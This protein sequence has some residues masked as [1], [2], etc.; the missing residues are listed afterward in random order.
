MIDSVKVYNFEVEDWHT[1]YVGRNEI[2][3]HNKCF[4]AGKTFKTGYAAE[5]YL[6]DIYGGTRNK[7]FFING[8][9]RFVDVYSNGVAMESKVGYTSATAFIKKQVLKDEALL[10]QKGNGVK[11]I[12]WHFSRSGRTG[13]MG[14]TP[15]LR[16]YLNEHHIKIVEHP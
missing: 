5:E 15:Q 4:Q 3:V 14:L 9:K 10:F 8:Q 13:K 12:E 11:K 2:L 7:Y 6:H 16:A 1:Y